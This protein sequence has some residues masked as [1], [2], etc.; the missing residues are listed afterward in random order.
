[1]HVANLAADI[2]VL[3]FHTGDHPDYH[4]QSDTS[5]KIDSENEA[6]IID[7]EIRLLLNGMKKNKLNF[8]KVNSRLLN[9]KNRI[10]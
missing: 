6:K 8:T 7:L 10:I 2:P 1:M 4:K 3:F 9:V 5:E